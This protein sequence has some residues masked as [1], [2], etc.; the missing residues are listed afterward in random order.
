M[1]KEVSA[2]LIVRNGKIF[3]AQRP[4]GKPLAN[5]WEFPGGKKEPEET[6]SQ[7]LQ[8]ELKEELNIDA[9]IEEF[10]MDTTYSYPTGTFKINFFRVH[11]AN[12]EEPQLNV[13][14]ASAWVTPEEMKNYNFPPA[15]EKIIYYL[16]KIKL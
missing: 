1:I 6:L 7:C 15:D 4:E 5:L 9:E 11:I 16:Q 3:I 2:A 10:L 12:D 14:K 13:H 8:R